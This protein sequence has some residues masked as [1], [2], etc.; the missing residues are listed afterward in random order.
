M[1]RK[2]STKSD[3]PARSAPGVLIECSDFLLSRVAMIVTELLEETLAPLGLRLRHYRLL[4]MLHLAGPQPQGSL[5]AALG[6]DRTTVVALVD[7]LERSRLAK[8]QR[9]EDRR[10][11]YVATT[12]KGDA[13]AIEATKRAN[14]I[15]AD[16]FAPLSEKE[17]ETLRRL[18]TELLAA[19]GPIAR[20]KH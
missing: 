10:A 14:A 4:R 2:V 13:L 5:G 19:P 12:P 3:T 11:Y 6:V 20:S 18:L 8:R 15:E 1:T 9:C 7:Y 16:M 17:Q